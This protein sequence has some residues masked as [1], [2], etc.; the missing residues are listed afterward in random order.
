[1]ACAPTEIQ[2]VDG[3]QGGVAEQGGEPGQARRRRFGVGGPSNSRASTNPSSTP[4]PSSGLT[5]NV[6]NTGP[7]SDSAC[8]EVLPAAP[9]RVSSY[10][11]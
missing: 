1:M 2:I 8:R 11:A 9:E 3:A 4:R 10:T 5:S 7:V 6:M